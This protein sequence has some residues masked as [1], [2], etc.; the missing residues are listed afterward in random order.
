[1]NGSL[2]IGGDLIQSQT[3]DEDGWIARISPYGN[4]LWGRKV[5]A[6][7]DERLNDVVVNESGDIFITGTFL[8]VLEI[9][10]MLQITTQGFNNNFFL[11]SLD[12]NGNPIWSKSLGGSE[13][14]EG[15]LLSYKNGPVV[16]G[17]FREILTIGELSVE[18]EAGALNGFVAGFS[19][20]GEV[21]WMLALP[22]TGFTIP[23]AMAFTQAGSL[24]LGG[25]FSE[26][27]FF[28][29]T[30]LEAE[31]PFDL[32]LGQV[33]EEVTP[34]RDE[35]LEEGI[36][37]VFP[38][39]ATDR[40]QVESPKP[41]DRWHLLD[42]GG[43]QLLRGLSEDAVQLGQLPAGVYFLQLFSQGKART[44]KVVKR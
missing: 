35:P 23:A 22:G 4:G 8:G 40:I 18:G 10:G 34:V 41:F 44:V 7:Y 25:S 9:G 36:I 42:A 11:A 20:T 37:R 43:R 5:G 27:A 28:D 12:K 33:L 15:L 2:E 38:N 30:T 32:F 24:V 31:G 29:D 3:D 14:E 19:E 13:N 26:Q 16:G 21:K 6:Q 1:M 39:P 17:L